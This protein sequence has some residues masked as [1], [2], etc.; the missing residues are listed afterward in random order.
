MSALRSYAA[1]AR[2]DITKIMHAFT[3]HLYTESSEGF[4]LSCMLETRR[5]PCERSHTDDPKR[6]IPNQRCQPLFCQPKCLTGHLPSH[7]AIDDHT[8]THFL[9]LQ[10]QSTMCD[11]HSNGSI[12]GKPLKPYSCWGTPRYI[13]SPLY[14]ASFWSLRRL[15]VCYVFQPVEL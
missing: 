15:I 6:T 12:W 7:S 2:G 13:A 9:T 3:A 8:H 11:S 4:L 10:T 5:F 1:Y 14:M